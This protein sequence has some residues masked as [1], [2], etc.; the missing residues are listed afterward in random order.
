MGEQLTEKPPSLT[1]GVQTATTKTLITRTMTENRRM[2]SNLQALTWL[3]QIASALVPPARQQ[4]PH[5]HRDI[6]QENLLL[7]RGPDGALA[8]KLADLGLH[9]AARRQRASPS[10]VSPPSVPLHRARVLL[11]QPQATSAPSRA[12]SRNGA[13]TPDRDAPLRGPHLRQRQRERSGVRFSVEDVG[14]APRTAGTVR[15]K[16]E[17]RRR[18]R[19]RV[20]AASAGGSSGGAFKPTRS[21]REAAMLGAAAEAVSGSWAHRGGGWLRRAAAPARPARRAHRR[22]GSERPGRRALRACHGG[23]ATANGDGP[24]VASTVTS[25]V[26]LGG[27]GPGVC[28]PRGRGGERGRAAWEAAWAARVT[29]ARDRRRPQTLAAGGAAHTAAAR[30]GRRGGRCRRATAHATPWTQGGS[31]MYMAPEVYR[32]L[33]YNEKADVF[34]PRVMA[35]AWELVEACWHDDPVQRPSMQEVVEALARLR[36]MELESPS[37]S[38]GVTGCGCVIS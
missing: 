1:C 18:Q 9:V 17:R 13:D 7:K 3:T 27:A 4:P 5:H 24:R 29:A 22:A 19:R 6:K 32:K 28:T 20:A 33:P 23:R 10:A 37:D 26:G 30:L 21:W 36:A 35:E 38:A 11:P 14:L 2:Y 31:C 12:D 25:P 8:A 34:R 16:C 15:R